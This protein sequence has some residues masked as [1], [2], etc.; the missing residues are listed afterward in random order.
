MVDLWPVQKD[1]G[2]FRLDRHEKLG[3][4]E[5]TNEESERRWVS[6]SNG[7]KFVEFH[8]KF[9]REYERRPGPNKCPNDREKRWGQ[10]TTSTS[11]DTPSTKR[12][13]T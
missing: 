7:F 1:C 8:K 5:G 10:D 6:K 11:R 4:Y 12:K 2:Y 3:E 13:S 9:E